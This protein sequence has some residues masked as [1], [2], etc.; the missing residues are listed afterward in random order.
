[1][2]YSPGAGESTERNLQSI[3]P[4]VGRRFEREFQAI[5]PILGLPLLEAGIH[6]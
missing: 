4:G 3:Q 6:K 1:M 5:S 2:S